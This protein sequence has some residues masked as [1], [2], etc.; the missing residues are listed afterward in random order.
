MRKQFTF[1]S[2]YYEAVAE[3]PKK[4]QVAVMLAICAYALMDE[5]PVLSGVPKAIFSLIRPTLDASRA[6]AEAGK[7]GAEAKHPASKPQAD[8][9]QSDS[10]GEA[11]TKQTASEKENEKENECYKTRSSR[12]TPPTFEEVE[13]YCQE[14]RNGVD[15]QRFIDFYSAKGWMV[16]KNKMKDWKAAVRTWEQRNAADPQPEPAAVPSSR[17][18]SHNNPADPFEGHREYFVDGKWVRQD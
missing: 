11:E 6:K 7:R 17:W 1:Y 12:F 16:G 13:A 18:I 5:E 15:P 3:L 4:D 2:S 9:K 14:R 10:K 8:A